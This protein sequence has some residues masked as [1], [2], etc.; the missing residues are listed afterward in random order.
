MVQRDD[1][2]GVHLEML[3][4]VGPLGIFYL[5]ELC[6]DASVGNDDVEVV[7]AVPLLE[8]VD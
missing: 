5:R 1:P 7:Q 3:Q 8:M 2:E 4:D 6:H